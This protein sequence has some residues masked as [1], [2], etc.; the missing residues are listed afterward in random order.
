MKKKFFSLV[1]ATFLL[2][3]SAFT[4]VGC[5]TTYDYDQGI[6]LA[7]KKIVV[8]ID[9][10]HVDWGFFGYS[11]TYV[12]FEN[13]KTYTVEMT[14]NEFIEEFVDDGIFSR[15]LNKPNLDTV[16]KVKAA[17]IEKVSLKDLVQYPSFKFSED[18]SK[19]TKYAVTDTGFTT[20][21][22]TYTVQLEQ[23]IALRRYHY[24]ENNVKKG[25]I[26]CTNIIQYFPLEE[27]SY[28]LE[29]DLSKITDVM[30]TLKA[31]DGSTKKVP[32]YRNGNENDEDYGRILAVPVFFQ[33]KI[34][35]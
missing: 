28:F 20:P 14:L 27:G 21:L 32:I 34:A 6:D 11:N 5:D 26:Q 31:D 15:I 3:L 29:L 19:V 2:M 30:V 23:Q 33:Y 10:L 12:D 25:E 17:I 1:L 24:F 35:E 7:G 13:E 18:A 16:E 8:D 4:F 22:A 9:T